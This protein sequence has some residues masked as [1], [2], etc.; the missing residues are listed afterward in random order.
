[1]STIREFLKGAGF[2]W[3]SGRVIVHVFADKGVEHIDDYYRPSPCAPFH[4][5]S[6]IKEVVTIHG[7]AKH[8][9][10]DYE[11]S[12]GHGGVECPCFVAYDKNRI[13]FPYQYDGSTSCDFVL[14]DSGL[15]E[16]GEEATPYPGG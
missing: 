14:R 4:N 7:R 13:Y 3:D 5:T 6:E 11:F 9:S 12:S 16:R 15:Y 1:M 8:P 10:L 2:D